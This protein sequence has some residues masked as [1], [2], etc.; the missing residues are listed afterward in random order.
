MVSSDKAVYSY[1]RP[2]GAAALRAHEWRALG[3]APARRPRRVSD[4]SEKPEHETDIE[5]WLERF[6]RR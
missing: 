2:R 4:R 3:R 1:A 5:G 6:T